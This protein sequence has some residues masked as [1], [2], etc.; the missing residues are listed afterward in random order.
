MLSLVHNLLDLQ[1][2]ERGEISKKLEV[3]DL[4]KRIKEDLA[5]LKPMAEKKNIALEV[6]LPKEPYWVKTDKRIFSQIVDNL[7]S[8]AIKFSPADKKVRILVKTLENKHR[9]EVEDQGPGILP[10]EEVKLFKDFAR[11]SAK[12]TGDE[13]STGL[14]LSTSKKFAEMLNAELFYERPLGTG[15][16]FVLM[17]PDADEEPIEQVA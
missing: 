14:G 11:L 7:V 6:Q 10:E 1:T 16:R 12:P 9:L 5:L 17:F 2:I 13:S 4:A 15:A 3:I 8:N